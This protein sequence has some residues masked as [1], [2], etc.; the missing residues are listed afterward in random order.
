MKKE[1]DR[2]FSE[3]DQILT[4]LKSTV[5]W[6]LRWQIW[7]R[8]ELADHSRRFDKVEE[9]LVQIVNNLASK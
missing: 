5:A 9:L 7:V 3:H 8:E 2:R 6:I 4:G 1:M